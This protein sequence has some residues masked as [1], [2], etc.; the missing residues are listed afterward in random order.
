ML[1]TQNARALLFPQGRCGEVVGR[2]R[3]G[4]GRG[5][6]R[7]LCGWRDERERDN[8]SRRGDEHG[9]RDEERRFL[10][11]MLVERGRAEVRDN[12]AD[13]GALL[14]G[15]RERQRLVGVG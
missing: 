10:A 6:K 4:G 15:G 8:Q 2:R 12:G 13:A 7:G 5:G 1:V 14:G 3:C 11:G 9:A